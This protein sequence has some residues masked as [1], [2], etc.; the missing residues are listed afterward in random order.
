M[1]TS[2]LTEILKGNIDLIN[3]VDAHDIAMYEDQV[4]VYPSDVKL[5]LNKYL[6]NEITVDEL[7]KWGQFLTIRGEYGSPKQEAGEDEDFY[8][9]MWDVVQALSIPK[10]DG[11][12]TEEKVIQYLCELD[13]YKD[14]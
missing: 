5:I 14:A 11:E 7:S 2:D 6:A 9:S 12:I 4:P 13:K 10:I 1:K 8:E 3:H